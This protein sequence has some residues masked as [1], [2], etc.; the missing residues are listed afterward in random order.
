MSATSICIIGLWSA[1]GIIIWVD[2]LNTL[3][4]EYIS[5]RKTILFTILCGPLA[6][7]CG[8]IFF[9]CMILDKISPI[10]R[11]EKW[12]LKKDHIC[13]ADRI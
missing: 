13:Y 4:Y 7:I 1:V 12:L 5:L 2:I 6:I 3:P 9:F 10:K 8:V 11:I